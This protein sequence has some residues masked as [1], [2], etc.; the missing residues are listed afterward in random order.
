MK[1]NRVA[2]VLVMY[3]NGLKIK[4]HHRWHRHNHVEGNEEN[5]MEVFISMHHAL[6][7]I[8]LSL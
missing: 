7:F 5:R 4:K 1:N 8:S 2:H 3:G 6:I